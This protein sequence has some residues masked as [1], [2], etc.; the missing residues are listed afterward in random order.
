MGDLIGH[1]RLFVAA[2]F[3]FSLWSL[4]AGVSSYSGS[5]VFFIICRAFQGVAA[6]AL[7]PSAL[8]ILGTIYKPGPRKNLVFSLYASG[9]PIGFTLGAFFSALLAQL[10]VESA[11]TAVFVA[12]YTKRRL[13]DI[14]RQDAF[15]SRVIYREADDGALFS[16]LSHASGAEETGARGPCAELF[17]GHVQIRAKVPERRGAARL[18]RASSWPRNPA[19]LLR[20]DTSRN[21]VHEDY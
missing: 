13:F 8:A 3:W 17:A 19:F 12:A 10:D 15:A 11:N 20:T 7:V 6:A 14:G 5:E 4:I 16:R 1:K 21:R 9:A 18:W 2:W